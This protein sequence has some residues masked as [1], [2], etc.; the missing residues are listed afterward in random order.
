MTLFA[1]LFVLG[2]LLANPP[3]LLMSLIPIFTY[4]VGLSIPA[5]L[6]EAERTGIKNSV[7]VGEKLR[8]QVKGTIKQGIG[9]VTIWDKLPEPFQLLSG[10]NY[11]VFWKG[12]RDKE[13]SC[14][15]EILCRKRGKFDFE[16]VHCESRHFLSL[17]EPSYGALD[18]RK[19]LIVRSRILFL[20]RIRTPPNIASTL[21]PKESISKLGAVSTNFQSLREY[22][23]GDPFK[24]INWKATARFM[25]KG[26]EDLLVNE[27]EREGKR[28]VWIFLDAHPSLLV[29]TSVENCFD[30]CVEAADS[31]AYYFLSQGFFLGM[32]IYHAGTCFYPDTGMKQYLKIA[33]ELISL[34][35]RFYYETESL[36]RT[37]KKTRI[38]LANLS[39]LVIIIT[40]LT[41]E[42]IDA[43]IEGVKN[44]LVHYRTVRRKANVML[45]NVLPY[46][47]IPQSHDL[48]QTVREMLAV[49]N[50]ALCRRLQ[51]AGIYVVNWNPRREDF[52]SK[53]MKYVRFKVI[54]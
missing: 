31:V 33:R 24:F 27:F 42:R 50:R 32:S 29:G 9:S 22:M 41:A 45:I 8:V 37:V 44:I 19:E 51:K 28:A 21:Y 39:P 26:K 49:D 48:E 16:K 43:L 38:H 52:G 34:G 4:L 20:R 13:F 10:S 25:A 7:F 3:I 47:L 1:T 11:R 6:V 14:E 5:P 23:P 40:H 12:I 53:L 17:R 15:Y 36:A 18:E 54:A 2:L 46:D 30:H 35:P